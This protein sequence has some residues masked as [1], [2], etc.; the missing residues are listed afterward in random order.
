[1]EWGL[2]VSRCVNVV[3]KLGVA[4]HGIRLA[5]TA[6]GQ[7]R[8]QSRG[9]CAC[10][11]I[12]REQCAALP[13]R[14]HLFCGWDTF[15]L[16]LGSDGCLWNAG[17]LLCRELAGIDVTTCKNI[18]FRGRGVPCRSCTWRALAI[19]DVFIIARK[20]L[21]SFPV[22]PFVPLAMLLLLRYGR[23][24]W[25]LNGRLLLEHTL[26]EGFVSTQAFHR[27]RCVPIHLL[28]HFHTSFRLN[29]FASNSR[30]LLVFHLHQLSQYSLAT[31]FR[32]CI[33]QH[34]SVSPFTLF[35]LL[36]ALRGFALGM[37]FRL[38]LGALRRFMLGTLFLLQLG[39]LTSFALGMLFVLH[40]RWFC[41]FTFGMF[42]H[43]HLGVLCSCTLLM[44]ILL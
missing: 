28:H 11:L 27:R 37:L 13:R 41:S 25:T 44:L 35:S 18:H 20:R 19:G 9:P 8:R 38:H 31:F 22:Y 29:L 6:A 40:S 24:T 12:H 42:S 34:H 17:C 26:I 43:L 23:L 16:S 7:A 36:G 1:M 32:L 14:D 33:G 5:A 30:T 2:V 39:A 15:C 10:A 21:G 4:R 3:H